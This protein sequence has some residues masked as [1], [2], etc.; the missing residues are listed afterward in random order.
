MAGSFSDYAENKVLELIVGKTAFATPDVWVALGSGTTL[1]AFT[2]ITGSTNYVRKA[3]TSG[4]A[5][6]NAA[7]GGAIDNATAIT[8]A[9]A[10]NDWNSGNEIEEVALFN[11]ATAG[12]MLARAALT[13]PKIVLNGDTAQIPVGDLDL[14]LS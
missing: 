7:S 8:F 12:N 3:L 5:Y 14:T 10:G 1:D 4:G 2:E 6:W 13:T 9:T 11:H